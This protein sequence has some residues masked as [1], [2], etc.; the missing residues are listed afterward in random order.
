MTRGG[1]GATGI[2]R[3]EARHAGPAILVMNAPMTPR[4]ARIRGRGGD[5]TDEIAMATHKAEPRQQA[6]GTK[7]ACRK[8]H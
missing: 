5:L 8:L 6:K 4:Q 7:R 3:T 1:E 2:D